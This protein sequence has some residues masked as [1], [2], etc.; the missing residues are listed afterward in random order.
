MQTRAMPSF[1]NLVDAYYRPLFR[2]A[3][4]LSHNLE[5]A[6]QL[7]QHTFC[8][9]LRRREPLREPA[10]TR[11]WLFTILFSEFL[12]QRAC[13]TLAAPRH[14]PRYQDFTSPSRGRRASLSRSSP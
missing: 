7:T 4:S 11:Q 10:K 14:S 5:S 9:A 6:L 12:Q 1:E 2:F 8:V 3:V 13:P